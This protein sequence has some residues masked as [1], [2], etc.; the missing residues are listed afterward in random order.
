MPFPA[1]P[2]NGATYTNSNGTTYV[3][4]TAIQA[5]TVSLSA[6]PVIAQATETVI[7][8]GQIITQGELN[9]AT[10]LAGNDTDIVTIRKLLGMSGTALAAL[11]ALIGPVA[12]TF[13]AGQFS[14]GSTVVVSLGTSV[15]TLVNFGPLTPGQVINMPG[16]LILNNNP[17]AMTVSGSQ[18]GGP[19]GADHI[20]TY[21]SWMYMGVSVSESTDAGGDTTRIATG[22]FTRIA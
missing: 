15:N 4:E 3:Y 11:R 22:H 19:L 21:G 12:P 5:W 17:A 9:S 8:G 1:S 20:I 2:A 16:G 7:G 18:L 14:V 6:T 10:A 13:T